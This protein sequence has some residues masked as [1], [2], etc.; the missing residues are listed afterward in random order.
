[1]ASTF[2]KILNKMDQ[3][4]E[5]VADAVTGKDSRQE[6]EES[7]EYYQERLPEQVQEGGKIILT[8]GQV[9]GDETKG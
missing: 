7:Q 8:R 5:Q 2:D 3:T 6:A 4:V 1:M 9:E